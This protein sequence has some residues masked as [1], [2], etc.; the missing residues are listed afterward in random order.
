METFPDV[1]FP[2]SDAGLFGSYNTVDFPQTPKPQVVLTDVSGT[3]KVIPKSEDGLLSDAWKVITSPF[4]AVKDAAVD[5]A[6][7][8]ATKVRNMYLYLIGGIAL[9]GIIAIIVLGSASR[10]TENTR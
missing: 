8:A 7:G 10:F 5:V 6:E 4:K 3:G 9:I 2:M 1:D